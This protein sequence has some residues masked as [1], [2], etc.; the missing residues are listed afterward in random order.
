M[1]PDALTA[2]GF[3]LEEDSPDT[4]VSEFVYREESLLALSARWHSSR[5]RGGKRT[6]RRH[7]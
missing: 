5:R 1:A 6:K 7:P 2:D 3:V 4:A